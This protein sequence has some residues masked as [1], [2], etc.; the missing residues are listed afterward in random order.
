MAGCRQA[1]RDGHQAAYEK[2]AQFLYG[3]LRAAWERALEEVLL[4]GV[5]ERF[6][7]GVK[8]QHI[9]RIA[10]VTE[11][12]CRVL[13]AAMT[14]CSKWLPGHDQAAAARAAVPE[15]A[16]VKAD[17]DSLEKWVAAIRKRRD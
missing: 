3:L 10:D 7:P 15:S 16:D 14:K 1:F 2:E 8:T 6:R 4:E 12:D 9:S 13:D 5:V 11:N 17:I